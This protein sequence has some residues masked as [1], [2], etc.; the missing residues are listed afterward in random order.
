MRDIQQK[1]KDIWFNLIECNAK[2]RNNYKN[3]PLQLLFNNLDQES[4]WSFASPEPKPIPIPWT[5][6][7]I[8]EV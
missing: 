7:Q 8:N 3:L 4:S 5:P 6:S 1:N 2:M